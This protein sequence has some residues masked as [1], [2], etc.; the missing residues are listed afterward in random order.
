MR[1]EIL[2]KIQNSPSDQVDLGDMRIPDLELAEVMQAIISSRPNVEEIFLNNCNISDEGATIVAHHLSKI[3]TL[4]LLDI[5][6]NAIA[7]SGASEIYSLKN[8]N[9]RLKILF[10]GNQIANVSEIDAIDKRSKL[11]NK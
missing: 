4:K 2:N 5:Q 7:K 10:H 8:T 11:N 9:Q 3:P 1:F 6:H